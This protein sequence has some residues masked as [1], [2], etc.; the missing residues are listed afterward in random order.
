MLAR[1]LS[2]VTPRLR[3][4]NGLNPRWVSR[5]EAV[6]AAYVADPLIFDK[7]TPRWYMEVT[8]AQRTLVTHAHEIRTPALFLLAGGDRIA[9]HRI[10]LD[11]FARLGTSDKQLR[12]YPELYHEVFNEL[13]AAREVVIGD[14]LAWLDSRLAH[15]LHDAVSSG[16]L[17]E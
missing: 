14:L 2:L 5:D 11:V 7:T 15:S 12:T 3:L 17:H 1:V 6:V 4:P 9:D 10:A 13:A 16:G 8:A